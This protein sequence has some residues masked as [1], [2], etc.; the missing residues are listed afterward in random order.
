VNG[1]APD[2]SGYPPSVVIPIAI[3]LGVILSL[4]I[5]FPITTYFQ[6]RRL[7]KRAAETNR[8]LAEIRAGR[9][10]DSANPFK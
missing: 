2:I 8:L 9:E 6:L 4:W 3:A 1:D 7:N 10:V 5:L